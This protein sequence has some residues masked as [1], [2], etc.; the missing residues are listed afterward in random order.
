MKG[1]KISMVSSYYE[2]L[3][4]R[5]NE[6]FHFILN[7]KV[8]VLVFIFPSTKKDIKLSNKIVLLKDFKL[9]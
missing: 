7:S 8:S 1:K 6:V 9:Y 4:Y 5:Q 3:P 2:A